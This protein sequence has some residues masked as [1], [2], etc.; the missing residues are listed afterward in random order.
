MRTVSAAVFMFVEFHQIL[1]RMNDNEGMFGLRFRAFK[2][3]TAFPEL[4]WPKAEPCSC[5]RNDWVGRT[6]LVTRAVVSHLGVA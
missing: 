2:I 6:N 1:Y 4:V 3:Q 5:R